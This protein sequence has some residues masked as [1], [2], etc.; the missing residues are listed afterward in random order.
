[1]L[2]RL[3]SEAAA[4]PAREICG[5]L[6]GT[7]RSIDDARAAANV[8]ADPARFFEVDPVVL[9]AALRTERTGGARVI[10]SYHSH[11]SGSA[12][13]SAHDLAAAQAGALS[14]I[15]TGREARLWLATAG[16]FIEKQLTVDE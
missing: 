11:P 1:M 16:R 13:P 2:E 12:I 10:G 15:V 3:V 14:L 7:V 6:F 8:A 5:L 4:D 9:I